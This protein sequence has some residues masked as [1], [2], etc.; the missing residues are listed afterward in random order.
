[1]VATSVFVSVAQLTEIAYA[2]ALHAL[3]VQMRAD[4]R[5]SRHNAHRTAF[6]SQLG[7]RQVVPHLARLVATILVVAQPQLPVAVEA[8][9][10]DTAVVQDRA[11]EVRSRGDL[12]SMPACSQLHGRQRVTHLVVCV[13]TILRV[14]QPQ[15]PF[16]VEAPALDTAVIQK[17]AGVEVSSHNALR[18]AVFAQVDGRQVVT[19]VRVSVASRFPVAQSQLPLAVVS[20]ALDAALV[21]KR[22]GM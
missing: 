4:V 21:Q 11:R 8:P 9:A 14:S 5:V 19:H 18:V 10:L 22:A 3:V 2:P 7:G 15:L 1:M 20:P 6:M 13:A 12:H 16:V 17:R